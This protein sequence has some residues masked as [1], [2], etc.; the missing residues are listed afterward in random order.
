M[1]ILCFQFPLGSFLKRPGSI[2]DLCHYFKIIIGRI[3]THFLP[4]FFIASLRK[5]PT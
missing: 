4:L 1:S 2:N 5:F 3:V